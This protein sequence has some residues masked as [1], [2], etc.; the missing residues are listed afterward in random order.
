MRKSI[1]DIETRIDVDYEFEKLKEVLGE[2]N[3][4]YYN[5]ESYSLYKYL[6]D[7]IL[8]IW[9][10][11]GIFIDFDDFSSRLEIDFRAHSCSKEKF[12]YILELLVNLWPIAED[13]LD[14]DYKQ[15]FSKK[16]IGYMQMNL[17]LIIERMNY[18]IKKESGKYRL[19]KRDSDVDSVL[20]ISES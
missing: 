17:P 20:D 14:F 15:C 12:L 7:E 6:N 18:Q 10:Y 2:N 5:G 9:E 3:T 16:V 4:L 1:F 19:I 11:K 13:M 8:P